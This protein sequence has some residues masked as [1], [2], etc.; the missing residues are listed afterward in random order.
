MAPCMDRLNVPVLMG[1]SGIRFGE[2]E[3]PGAGR[4]ATEQGGNGW[5]MIHARMAGTQS[6]GSLE[7]LTELIT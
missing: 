4:D 6:G 7:K 5:H 1:M 3:I 2:N